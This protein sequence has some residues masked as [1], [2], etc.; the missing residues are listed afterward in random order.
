[1]EAGFVREVDSRTKQFFQSV[2]EIRGLFNIINENTSKLNAMVQT[3]L[4]V[5]RESELNRHLN[6]IDTTVAEL[7][8]YMLNARG[9]IK[10][11]CIYLFLLYYICDFCCF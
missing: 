6:Q 11:A 3:A 7:N 5:V 9:R 8:R 10:G 1:M 2:N 4:T